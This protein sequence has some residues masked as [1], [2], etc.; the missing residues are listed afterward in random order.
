MLES[1]VFDICYNINELILNSQ[2]D[3]ART[4]V[5]K[6][7]DRLNR[8]GKEYSPMVNHF[9]REVGLFPYI[10]KNTAS[11]QEQAVFEAYKTDLGGGEQKTLHSAQSRVLK[12]LLAGDNSS[13]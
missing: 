13:Y 6:L 4:E 1:E 8:E 12:R 10:D 9:I 11:W 2:M 7:L 5:I 3:T